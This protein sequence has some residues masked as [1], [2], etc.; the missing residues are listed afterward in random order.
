MGQ[1]SVCREHPDSSIVYYSEMLPAFL[2]LIA[3]LSKPTSWMVE[4][5]YLSNASTKA[6]SLGNISH[7]ALSIVLYLS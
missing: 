6:G 1:H 7:A 5:S 4:D 3:Q 2:F